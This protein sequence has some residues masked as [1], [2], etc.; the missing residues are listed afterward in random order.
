MMLEAEA[1]SEVLCST[2]IF[3][4]HLKL[5]LCFFANCCSLGSDHLNECIALSEDFLHP[6]MC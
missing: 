2:P 1:Q 5:T 4:G 3:H 6:R